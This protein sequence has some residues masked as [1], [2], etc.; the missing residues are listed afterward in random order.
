MRGL[1]WEHGIRLRVGNWEGGR[2]QG[3]VLEGKKESFFILKTRTTT[4]IFIKE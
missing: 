4:T 3:N 1:A 2:V